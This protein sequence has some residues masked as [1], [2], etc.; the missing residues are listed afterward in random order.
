VFHIE[1]GKT[2]VKAV[3]VTVL[4]K[5]GVRRVGQKRG[6]V[7]D[8]FGKRVDGEKGKS[9]GQPPVERYLKRVVTG[10]PAAFRK[11]DVAVLRI[12]LTCAQIARAGR[13]LIEI[14]RADQM[15]A[16]RAGVG[17]AQNAHTMNV[18]LQIQIPGLE[19]GSPGSPRAVSETLGRDELLARG[20]V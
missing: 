6:G 19:I 10:V 18:S 15:R 20:E 7:V 1:T 12:R 3:I 17:Y 9:V 13:R 2:P 16:L 8:R 4:R 5:I 14:Q 11:E